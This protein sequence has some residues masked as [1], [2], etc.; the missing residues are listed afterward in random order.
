MRIKLFGTFH[1]VHQHLRDAAAF[2]RHYALPGFAV[3]GLQR[4]YEHAVAAQ[5]V[6]EAFVIGYFCGFVPPR[7][8]TDGTVG[9]RFRNQHFQ[10]SLPLNLHN[11]RAFVFKVARQQNAG[12]Q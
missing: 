11:Q 6:A 7:G 5:K 2:Q 9:S 3:F 12:S 10:F 4:Q 8:C 1:I